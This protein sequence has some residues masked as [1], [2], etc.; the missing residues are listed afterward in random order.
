MHPLLGDLNGFR[1]AADEQLIVLFVH[2]HLRLGAP[3]PGFVVSLGV[4]V[5]FGGFV[6]LLMLVV[7][8]LHRA[9]QRRFDSVAL[10]GEQKH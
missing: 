4:I 5:V 2:Q 8:A 7:I 6:A 9:N 10:I 3:Q 1:R